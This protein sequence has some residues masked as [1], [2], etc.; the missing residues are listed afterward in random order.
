MPKFDG[1]IEAVR[2]RS[3][4]ID[5]VRAYE[6]RG[7]TFSDHVLIDRK[8]LLERLKGGKRFVTG[9][10]RELLASTFQVGKP[11]NLVGENG[12]QVVTTLAQAEHDELE[13]VPV[14]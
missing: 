5:V 14:F 12:R 10:R 13:G 4:K 2:Y 1:V 9:Q 8:T 3:G 11:V 6:R 7:P